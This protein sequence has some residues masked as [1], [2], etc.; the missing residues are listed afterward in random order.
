M[1]SCIK[2][3]TQRQKKKVSIKK[4]DGA[5]QELASSQNLPSHI[6]LW[7]CHFGD[8]AHVCIKLHF[9]RQHRIC[10][11]NCRKRMMD[12]LKPNA[13]SCELQWHSFEVRAFTASTILRVLIRELICVQL[14]SYNLQC[15]KMSSVLSY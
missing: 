15:C 11:C 4:K 13:T 5:Y 14:C 3:P 8:Q 6:N 10:Y 7:S 9:S 12:N 2:I 1:T